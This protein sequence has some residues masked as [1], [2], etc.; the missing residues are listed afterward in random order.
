MVPG[1]WRA[2]VCGIEEKLYCGE[3]AATRVSHRRGGRHTGA[4]PHRRRAFVTRR[5]VRTLVEA[6]HETV[7]KIEAAAGGYPGAVEGEAWKAG[8]FRWGDISS[9]YISGL[10]LAAP[11]AEKGWL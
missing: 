6:Q 3:S 2:A 8:R 11:L 5:P 10:L 4:A 1:G 7:V 9:Q